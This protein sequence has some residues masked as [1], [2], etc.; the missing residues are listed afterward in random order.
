MG[1]DFGRSAEF[2]FALSIPGGIAI[3]ALF[4]L[5][6]LDGVAAIVAA[7]AMLALS[8][9]MAIASVLSLAR[10][11][12]AIDRLGPAA[13]P[14]EAAALGHQSYRLNSAATAASGFWSNAICRRSHAV[15]R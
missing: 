8:V 11:R 10:T 13:A 14:D 2:A 4:A 7:A 9:L 5:G 1:R 6:Y 12:A 15:L 3:A